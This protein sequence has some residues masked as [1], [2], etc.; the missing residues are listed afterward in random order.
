ML[1]TFKI[2]WFAMS[3]FSITGSFTSKKTNKFIASRNIQ[4]KW[5]FFWLQFVWC[6]QHHLNHRVIDIINQLF[7]IIKSHQTQCNQ[8][9]MVCWVCIVLHPVDHFRWDHHIQFLVQRKRRIL[10]IQQVFRQV[11]CHEDKPWFIYFWGARLCAII[12]HCLV[13]AHKFELH[14]SNVIIWSELISTEI[15]AHIFL[16]INFWLYISTIESLH[17]LV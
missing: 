11:N 10:A 3:D 1:D 4:L 5:E 14:D 16:A 6:C 8:I 15:H 7:D 9:P 2:D 13:W 17:K 12:K